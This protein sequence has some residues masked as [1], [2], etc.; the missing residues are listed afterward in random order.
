M[1]EM[2][3]EFAEIYD[4]AMQDIPYEKWCGNIVRLLS[5]QGIRDGLLADLGCGTGIMT[6]LLAR[7]GYDMTGID[8]S[9]EMLQLALEK[10]DRSGLPILYLN[11]DI[12]SFEL[13]GTMRA[14]VS[15]CDTMNYLTEDE[16]PVTVFRLVNNYLDPGGIFIFDL[17]TA[18][19]FGEVLGDLTE[20]DDS[21]PEAPYILENVFDPE[22]RLNEAA[23]T[24]FRREPSGFYRKSEEVHLQ[25]AWS[26][27]EIREAAEEAGMLFLN[28]LDAETLAPAGPESERIYI[29]LKEQGKEQKI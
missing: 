26:A 22:S 9:P 28:A 6:E 13:Y 16:D 3:S 19:Y 20:Y 15:V 17:K 11:Q 18:Y 23:L 14:F 25:R 1:E 24:I 5:E 27:G 21:D 4:R 10:R 8:L 29:L 7:A 2:Y 12:R